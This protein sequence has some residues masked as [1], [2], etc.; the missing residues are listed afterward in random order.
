MASH[1]MVIRAAGLG[2]W[3]TLVSERVALACPYCATRFGGGLGQS[4]ALGAFLALPFV[5]AGV[6]YSVLR[7]EVK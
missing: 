1:A 4:I 5:V 2:V 7:S 3:L 6:V